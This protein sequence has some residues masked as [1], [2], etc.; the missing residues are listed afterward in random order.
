MIQ[1]KTVDVGP[2][3]DLEGFEPHDEVAFDISNGDDNQKFSW[4]VWKQK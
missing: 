1:G 2:K 3:M 4:Q